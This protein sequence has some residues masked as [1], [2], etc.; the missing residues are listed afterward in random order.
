MFK[1][2]PLKKDRMR[3]LL[4]CFVLGS[5]LFVS[6]TDT[7]KTE[8]MLRFRMRLDSTQERLNN[9]GAPASIPAENRAQ[10]PRFNAIAVHYI[11]LASSPYTLLGQGSILYQTASTSQGGSQAILF[12]SLVMVNDN[13]VFFEIPLSQVPAGNYSW[14]RVSLA[15]Q[16]YDISFRVGPPQVP[17]TLN[18]TASVASFIG[19]NTYI[20][21]HLVKTLSETLNSNKLQGYWA[22]EANIPGYPAQLSSGQAPPGATTVP[23][24]LWQSSPIPA[25]SCV[26]TGP[27]D[28]TLSVN[29]QSNGDIEVVVS[30]STNKSFEWKESG[31]NNVYEPLAG[32]TV[33][34]MG[35]RGL[36]STVVY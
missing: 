10:N 11:E 24:P 13:E 31:G 17:V 27:F 22:F 34:D 12:D 19:Y 14:I 23:N 32:D 21:T 3:I 6:C 4:L 35:I 2:I 28:K 25:G 16:N 1:F 18:G 20:K 30:L 29:A 7:G 8:P 26:V 36:V 33:V 9:I 5:A 15:Y